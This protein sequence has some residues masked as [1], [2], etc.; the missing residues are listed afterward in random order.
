MQ[1]GGAGRR[2]AGGQAALTGLPCP[3][4]LHSRAAGLPTLA[5][6][7]THASV[8]PQTGIQEKATFVQAFAKPASLHSA[9]MALPAAL[10]PLLLL[11]AVGVLYHHATPLAHQHWRQQQQHQD[12]GEGDLLVPGAA[13]DSELGA[14]SSD[15]DRHSA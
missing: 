2:R 15:D 8:P 1:G 3:A 10:V 11:T 12:E 13:D 4:R 5:H 14:H 9:A 6:T 7:H